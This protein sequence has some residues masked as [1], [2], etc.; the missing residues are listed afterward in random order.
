MTSGGC[1]QDPNDLLK[2]AQ[3]VFDSD[4]EK[5]V[6]F[7]LHV[8][9][10][11]SDVAGGAPPTYVGQAD[12][13]STITALAATGL[14]VVLGEFGPGRNIG[15]SPTLMTP[16]RIIQLAEAAKIGW[17]AWAW[18]DNDLPDAMADDSWFALS[19]SGA[20]NSSADLTIFGKV[21]V[22][23]PT[24]GLKVLASPASIFRSTVAATAVP[25]ATSAV[26]AV[27]GLALLALGTREADRRGRRS[28]PPSR[29][30]RDWAPA[31]ER[32]SSGPWTIS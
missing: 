23:D 25:S 3:A 24:R 1:G 10:S 18:D 16:S 29:L 9:G 17:L 7:D 14:V 4:P 31:L 12:L 20:Y 28:R 19:Y 30:A 27:L 32:D 2:W 11:Y 8:Y 13:P 6:I 15:P 5:N 22:E 21:V 26:M